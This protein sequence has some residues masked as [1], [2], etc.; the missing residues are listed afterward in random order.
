MSD[1]AFWWYSF[2]SFCENGSQRLE[3]RGTNGITAP[4]VLV[5]VVFV[6]I[7]VAG[8]LL[9]FAA[10]GTD[11][12]TYNRATLAVARKMV[13]YL[14]AVDRG[15]RDFVPAEDYRRAAA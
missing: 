6:T 10:C 15:Q 14:L 4:F 9:S 13:A 1:C 12:D 8:V 5:V 11:K 7:Q 3:G 2:H